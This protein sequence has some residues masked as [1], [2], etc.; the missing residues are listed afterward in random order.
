M[1]LPVSIS[2]LLVPAVSLSLVTALCAQTM[3]DKAVEKKSGESNVA[4]LARVK[5]K[6]ITEADLNAYT[7]FV[8]NSEGGMSMPDPAAALQDLVIQKLIDD[9]YTT[10]PLEDKALKSVPM[11]YREASQRMYLS[12][13]LQKALSEKTTATAEQ[14]KE[15]YDKN[16]DQQ[17]VPERI[18]AYHLFMATSKD[19]P[20]SS[21]EAV[22]KRME[23]VKRKADAGTSFSQLAS[24]FSE[25]SSGSEGGNLGFLSYRMPVGPEGR[26]MNIILDSALF[27]LKQG[28]VSPVL[29]TSHGLH[30]LYASERQTTYVP[31]LEDLKTSGIVGRALTADLM[32]K[33]IQDLLE[34]TIKKHGGKVATEEKVGDKLSTGTVAYE[35]DGKTITIQ[36]LEKVYGARFMSMFQRVQGDPEKRQALMKRALEDEAFIRAAIDAGIDEKPEVKKNLELM[37]ERAAMQK[38]LKAIVAQDYVADDAQVKALY[39]EKKDQMRRPEAAGRILSIKAEEGSSPAERAKNMAEAKKKAE[40]ALARIKKG[41]SFEAVAKEL[42]QDSRASSGGLIERHVVN[43]DDNEIVRQFDQVVM[44]LQKEGDVSNVRE[45][46]NVVVIVKLENKWP[47]EPAKLETVAPRIK[48]YVQHENEGRARKDLLRLLEAKGDVKWLP[49]S[50]KFLKPADDDIVV[51]PV[52]KTSVTTSTESAKPKQ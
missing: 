36:D 15:W 21:T 19:V 39:E 46:G 5:G 8:N 38:K 27:K 23:D 4:E 41:E 51:Q 28:E 48:M 31:S 9:V 17:A 16:K 44:G 47:G 6:A 13:E 32:N 29:E 30:L 50:D 11:K 14:M 24:K 34:K 45:L 40:D 25:A 12:N 26:P 18:H 7:E 10:I 2:S 35:I 33:A 3:P 43:N 20:S 49:A 52:S 22:R 37:A 42:S 1:R